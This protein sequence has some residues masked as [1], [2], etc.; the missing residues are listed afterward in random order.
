VYTLALSVKV[1]AEESTSGAGDAH[2]GK[3]QIVPSARGNQ[4]HSGGSGT[5]STPTPQ[6]PKTK[7]TTSTCA[8]TKVVSLGVF[9]SK[10][11]TV[12]KL[13]S[14]LSAAE[15]SS[16]GGPQRIKDI[17]KAWD[18]I[19]PGTYDPLS[20]SD[21]ETV[22]SANV[23]VAANTVNPELYVDYNTTY[24]FNSKS[25]LAGSSQATAK[26]ADDGTL[27]EGTG[28]VESKTLE[29]F[30]DLV[31]FSDVLKT[32]AT[33]AL[34]F[35]AEQGALQCSS[36][37]ALKAT[38]EFDLKI[39]TKAFKRTHSAIVLGTDSAPVK[40]PCSLLSTQVTRANYSA[41]NATVEEA[42]TDGDSKGDGNT[43][44]VNGTVIL[45][46]PAD[47]TSKKSE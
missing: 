46:K 16:S 26:L 11:Q 30:L 33:G 25:P 6:P 17:F 15:S 4:S 13:Q 29:T 14:L 43:V 8:F 47:K 18:A 35:A 21:D 37:A 1:T 42:S 34:P 12:Q 32:I 27:T 22:T 2:S 40:P 39:S 10:D 20:L 24:Y 7:S 38:Y 41:Y 23:Y 5:S 28:Q 3:D 44:K 45:P 36:P 9:N 31:P 19:T